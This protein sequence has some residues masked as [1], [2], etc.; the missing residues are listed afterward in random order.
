MTVLTKAAEVNQVANTALVQAKQDKKVPF[1]IHVHDGRLVPNVPQLGGDG[2]L[3]PPNPLYRPFRGNPKASLDE[4]MAYLA[5]GQGATGA[6]QTVTRTVVLAP[7]DVDPDLTGDDAPFDIGKASR[8][9]LVRFALDTYGVALSETTHLTRL[10]SE[11][12]KLARAT[13]APAEGLG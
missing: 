8:E 2:K 9:E 3:V 6:V 13:A 7:E 10:R 4:R 11:V 12:N 1:L 5:S